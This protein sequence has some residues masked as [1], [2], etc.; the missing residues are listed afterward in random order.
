MS[1][2]TN[3]SANTAAIGVFDS[4]VGGISVANAIADILPNE[5]IIYVAD[6]A[7]AP[8]GAKTEAFVT[9]RCKR[10]VDFLLAKQV[11][12]IV[13]ACNTATLSSIAHLRANYDMEFV[14]VEPGIKPALEASQSGVIGVM[15]TRNTLQSNQY[16]RL[17]KRWAADQTIINQACN[18]LVEQI[19]KA[20]FDAPDTLSLLNTFI[21]P[22]LEKGADQIVLGCT[23][24]GFLSHQIAALVGNQA[25]LINTSEA[26]ARRTAVLLQQL[27]L[28][29]NSEQ[30]GQ[31]SVYTSLLD[32]GFEEL[33]SQL[34][35]RV[36]KSIDTFD[37]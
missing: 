33:C 15:A 2:S 11:K 17:V 7:H 8:Y 9:A 25:Q 1:S 10:I 23:H 5:N 34:W 30:V 27:K 22:M 29:N 3:I 28:L 32:V 37:Y 4:G 36:V 31:I 26:I 13:V 20:Q 24:Y 6:T 35:D 18:G 19:E 14:G 21:S 16:Q 12:L